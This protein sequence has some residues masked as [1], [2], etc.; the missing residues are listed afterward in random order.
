M[1][2]GHAILGEGEQL[3]VL[4][5]SHKN[6]R[7][8]KRGFPI[9]ITRQS[10]GLS[11]PPGLKIFL[12]AGETEASISRQMADFIGPTTIVNQRKPE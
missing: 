1:F 5:L 3:L 8:L 11:I 4:G 12:F 10:H 2:T 6:L 7:R 9:K